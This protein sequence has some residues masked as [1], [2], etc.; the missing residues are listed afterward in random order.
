M[1]NVSDKS[2]RE[3]ENILCSIT[4]FENFAAYGIMWGNIV[5]PG[6][7]QKAIWYGLC[8]LFAG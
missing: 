5:H 7:P 2:C 8:A 3:N 4:V 6:R 1:R